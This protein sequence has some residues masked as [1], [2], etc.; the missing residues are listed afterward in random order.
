MLRAAAVTA[1][2]AAV[3]ATRVAARV[4]AMVVGAA[5][6]AA[7]AIARRLGA[8]GGRRRRAAAQRFDFVLREEPPLAALERAEAH[9]AD[10]VAQQAR[11]RQPDPG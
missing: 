5:L 9:R 3:G 7:V 8:V 10:L 1:L 2:W 4:A 11:H 6:R